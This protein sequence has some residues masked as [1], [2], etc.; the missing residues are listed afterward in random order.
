ME[1]VKGLLLH[2]YKV[3]N[4]WDYGSAQKIERVIFIG[5]KNKEIV[6]PPEIE[7]ENKKVLKDVIYDL[8]D[9]DEYTNF[10]PNILKYT[11]QVP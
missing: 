5:S 7:V 3:L 10:S 1:N 2:E 11:K 9:N 8:K 4:S 6:F